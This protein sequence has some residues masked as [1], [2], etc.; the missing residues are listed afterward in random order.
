MIV[1]GNSTLLGAGITGN[2]AS[3]TVTASTPASAT[4]AKFYRPAGDDSGWNGVMSN[5]AASKDWKIIKG[6][7]SWYGHTQDFTTS[8]SQWEIQ[9]LMPGPEDFSRYGFKV[10]FSCYFDD[11]DDAAMEGKDLLEVRMVIP[12]DAATRNTSVPAATPDKPYLVAGFIARCVGGKCC[13]YDLDADAEAKPLR[14]SGWSFYRRSEMEFTISRDNYQLSGGPRYGF[15]GLSL[16][17]ADTSIPVGTLCIRSGAN[18]VGKTGFDYLRSAIPRESIAHTLTPEDNNATFYCPWGYNDR[19]RVILPD[20]PFPEGFR[21][22]LMTD[23]EAPIYFSAANKNVVWGRMESNPP[24]SPLGTAYD[25]QTLIQTGKN[26][27]TWLLI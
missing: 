8:S 10:R 1:T 19:L 4:P 13:I 17:R 5:I 24:A 9:H 22:N 23:Y 11:V 20:I 21:V 27:K 14:I 3:P 18:P 15:G 6:V 7:S 16:T 2:S 26:G 12:D 25:K